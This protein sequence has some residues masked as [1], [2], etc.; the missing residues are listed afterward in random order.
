MT[1][2]QVPQNRPDETIVFVLGAL[3]SI[4]PTGG[5][6]RLELGAY[7][8]LDTE[9]NII[10]DHHIDIEEMGR[11]LKVL[12]DW[13]RLHEGDT[14]EG[15]PAPGRV[16]R[17]EP[18]PKGRN[19]EDHR[20]GQHV[21]NAG[22]L[23]HSGASQARCESECISIGLAI[24]LTRRSSAPRGLSS[25]P[26]QPESGHTP[27]LNDLRRT[28]PCCQRA[29]ASSTSPVVGSQ[30][31]RMFPQGEQAGPPLWSCWSTTMRTLATYSAPGSRW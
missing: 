4:R 8:L 30:P 31:P 16:L 14:N 11:K 26:K 24:A 5:R 7:Y 25:R 19:H 20:R 12:A 15:D 22:S 23:H 9:R 29:D 13:E 27:R 17:T 1:R 28:I 2:F 18:K 21:G 10:S 6:A 3:G